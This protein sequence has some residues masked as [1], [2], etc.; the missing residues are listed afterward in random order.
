VSPSKDPGQSGSTEAAVASG[1]AA[2]R[3]WPRSSRSSPWTTA[4][5]TARRRSPTSWRPSTR[6][7]FGS[8]TTPRTYGYGA[9]LR[10]GFQAA[11]FEP[12]SPS[13]T[14]TASSRSPTWAASPA[15]PP[16]ADAPDVVVGFRLKRADPLI[17]RWYARIY[18][19][20]N[21][22]FFGV[23]VRDIDCACKLFKREALPDPR[24]L[25]RRLLHRRAADQ[26][27]LQRP[28]DGR[29]RR[30]ALRPNRRLPNRRQAKGRLPRRPRLLVAALPP[31]VPPQGRAWS[32]ASRYWDS[33]PRQPGDLDSQ[34][35][36]SLSPAPGG[37]V[38]GPPVELIAPCRVWS[39]ASCASPD[40]SGP[41]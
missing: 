33:R 24:R 29:G 25:G 5:A 26:A 2:A 35:A 10:S 17:R 7:S 32:A 3:P 11:R 18:R 41:E 12:T 16:A 30:A 6:T 37:S 31:L 19:F 8:S 40:T 15:H 27:A 36:G 9:A 1:G 22:I 23:R 38:A 4:R 20:S 14:A 21:R 34:L 39:P 13:S 28:Q